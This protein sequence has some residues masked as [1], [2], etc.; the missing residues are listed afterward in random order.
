MLL[1]MTPDPAITARVQQIFSDAAFLDLLGITLEGAG[2]GWCN[3]SL[4]V[5]ARLL[6]Q[7][8]FVHAGVIATLADH[9][10]GGAARSALG[11]D[12][13]VITIEFK[14]NF[15]EPAKADRLEGRGVVLRAG[16]SIVA[17]ES[18][19]FAVAGGRRELVSKCISTLA[20]IPSAGGNGGARA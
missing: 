20:V 7:H 11:D 3:T 9:T 18:E 12:R 16:R 6:Q 2:H 10:C 17:A 15:L 13:D 19:V 4:P 14:I 1:R 5:D 8:G